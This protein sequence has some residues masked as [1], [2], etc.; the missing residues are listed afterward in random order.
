M[1]TMVQGTVTGGLHAFVNPTSSHHYLA[2]L[3]SCAD[4]RGA[5]DHRSSHRF[6]LRGNLT[7]GATKHS[8]PDTLPISYPPLQTA[9]PGCHTFQP[10]DVSMSRRPP[11]AEI[12]KNCH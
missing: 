10:G 6:S 5:V 4:Y 12:S 2:V 7:P 11:S 1:I 3:T 8:P 9:G